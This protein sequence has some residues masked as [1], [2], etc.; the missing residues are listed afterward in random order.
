MAQNLAQDSPWSP[1]EGDIV[2]EARLCVWREVWVYGKRRG[3]MGPLEFSKNRG[4]PKTASGV[5]TNVTANHEPANLNSTAE[6]SDSHRPHSAARAQQLPCRRERALLGSPEARVVPTAPALRTRAAA[7]KCVLL[8]PLLPPFSTHSITTCNSSLR[9]LLRPSTCLLEL[10]NCA[11]HPSPFSFPLDLH[12]LITPLF[13]PWLCC[14]PRPQLAPWILHRS[15]ENITSK[16][17]SLP[18]LLLPFVLKWISHFILLPLFNLLSVAF[19]LSSFSS[20]S[21]S[22]SSRSSSI[23]LYLPDWFYS[24]AHYLNVLTFTSFYLIT[25]LT[26]YLTRP[27]SHSLSYSSVSSS[28]LSFLLPVLVLSH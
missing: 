24:L 20:N 1:L 22:C 26:L 13:S 9:W 10:S 8:Q 21:Q 17:F 14:L 18:I 5:L 12:M 16:S 27:Q 3:F 19:G 4:S 25:H 6:C 23:S 28:S 15:F 7:A 11:G 2:F